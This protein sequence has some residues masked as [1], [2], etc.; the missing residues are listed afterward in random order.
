MAADWFA[1][2]DSTRTFGWFVTVAASLPTECLC[3]VLRHC[4]H[5]QASISSA[6][7][8]GGSPENYLT[9]NFVLQ[10]CTWIY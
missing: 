9:F 8:G 10:I 5:F 3:E 6:K 2:L 7:V 4:C 1:Q